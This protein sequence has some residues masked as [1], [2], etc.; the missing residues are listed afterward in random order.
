MVA[1]WQL[2]PS[3]LLQ[4]D[5]CYH[6]PELIIKLRLHGA[7]VLREA[8]ISMSKAG[9]NKKGHWRMFSNSRWCRVFP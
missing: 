9:K 4:P 8:Q 7:I 1:V 5:I 2:S 3:W 6:N